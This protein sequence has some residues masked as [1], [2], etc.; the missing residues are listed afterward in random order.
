MDPKQQQAK[1]AVYIA[2]A[3]VIIFLLA[4]VGG[5]ISTALSKL[6]EGIGL[7]SS[8]EEKQQEKLSE[9]ALSGGYLYPTYYRNPPKGYTKAALMYQSKASALAKQIWEG[10]NTGI[11]V[12]DNVGKIE[13]AFNEVK[14]KAQV[15]Q[16]A[17]T[18]ERTYK[19]SL[20]G[21]LLATFDRDSEI[22]VYNRIISKL[23]KLPTG[24]VK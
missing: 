16:L 24:F 4:K 17:E 7:Q 11:I 14:N 3:V 6:F 21:F 2:A 15:S 19:K 13:A 12:P 20:A 10:G 1:T 23:D 8:A 22:P 9:K 18:F 5:A